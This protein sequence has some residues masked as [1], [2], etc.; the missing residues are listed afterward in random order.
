MNWRNTKGETRLHEAAKIDNP[1]ELEQLIRS[2]QNV[3]AVDYAG[4]TPLMEAVSYGHIN[5]V[6]ILCQNRADV[7]AA[8]SEG[9][10]DEHGNVVRFKTSFQ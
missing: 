8:S 9:L 7:N 3:N 6:R 10:I 1:S 5:N 4:W 2:G